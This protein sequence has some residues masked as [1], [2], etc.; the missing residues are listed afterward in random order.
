MI[1]LPGSLH[2]KTGLRVAEVEDIN[3]FEPLRD[4]I[5]FGDDTITVKVNKRL[6]L[7]IGDVNERIYPGRARLPEYA[8]IFLICRGFAS[9]EG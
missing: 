9:Y 8:A 1:R 7:R 6:S 5:A 4:A 3:E 2:G